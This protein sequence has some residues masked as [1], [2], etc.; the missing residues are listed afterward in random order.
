M[1][2]GQ[3]ANDVPSDSAAIR[4]RTPPWVS[5]ACADARAF[6]GVVAERV[7]PGQRV[8]DLGT[9]TG[10]LAI[11]LAK[12]G[13]DVVAHPDEVR[14]LIGLA[15]QYAAVEPAMTGRENLVMV[16]RLF[17]HGRRQAKEAADIILLDNMT[18]A[19][20]KECYLAIKAIDQRI[21]V[22]VSGGIAP[23]SANGYARSA[24]VISLG[25]L[26]HSAPAL[27]LSMH[28]LE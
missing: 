26:T 8:L 6:A 7:R 3:F 22:E 23:R 1:A 20:A 16:A 28:I 27:P 17:G 21:T 2:S 12:A 18:P 10:L 19:Q 11:V 4:V 13:I 9:G 5:A 25:A 24:D 15:G 14:R